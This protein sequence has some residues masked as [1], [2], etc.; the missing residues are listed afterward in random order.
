MNTANGRGADAA[1]LE[2]FGVSKGEQGASAKIAGIDFPK[3]VQARLIDSRSGVPS[4][5]GKSWSADG[6]ALKALIYGGGF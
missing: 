2:R 5:F 4:L 6:V 3:D 1:A